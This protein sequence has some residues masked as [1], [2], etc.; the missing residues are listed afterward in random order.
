MMISVHLKFSPLIDKKVLWF[1]IPVQNSPRMAVGQ[2][3]QHLRWEINI[4]LLT[5]PSWVNKYF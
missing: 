5:I 2:T 3:S 4:D 1:E